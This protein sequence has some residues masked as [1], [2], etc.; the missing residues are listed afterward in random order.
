[1]ARILSKKQGGRTP[2]A[3]LVVASVISFVGLAGAEPQ[4]SQSG[5]GTAG[6][7]GEPSAGLLVAPSPNVTGRGA[8]AVTD[9]LGPVDFAPAQ[10]KKSLNSAGGAGTQ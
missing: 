3:T 8:G 4:L 5:T 10:P 9:G 6:G 7:P 2:A 1:M